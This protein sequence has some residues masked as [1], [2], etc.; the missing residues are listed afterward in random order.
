MSNSFLTHFLNSRNSGYLFTFVTA[1]YF[2]HAGFKKPPWVIPH[3]NVP[4]A[5]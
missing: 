5:D 3:V 4:T 2:I 1:D